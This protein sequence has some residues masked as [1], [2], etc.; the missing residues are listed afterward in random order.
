MKQ[1]FSFKK[2]SNVIDNDNSESQKKKS[3]NGSLTFG[4]LW[5]MEL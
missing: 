2:K 4:H 1:Y 5:Q 3:K